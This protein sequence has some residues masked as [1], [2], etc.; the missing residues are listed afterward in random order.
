VGVE[1][2]HTRQVSDIDPQQRLAVLI[3]APNASL[4]QGG[5]ACL[6]VQWFRE[7]SKEGVDVRLLVHARSKPELDRALGPLSSRI[8][9]VSENALQTMIWKIGEAM[10]MNI[11]YF[12]AQLVVHL[13]TQIVQRGAAKRL[14][15]QYKINVVHEPMPVAPRFPSTMYGLGVPV[16]IG[17]MNGNMTY[18]PAY[19]SGRSRIERTFVPAARGFAN[20]ANFLIPGKRRADVLL[21]ANERTR[22]ALPSGCR[23]RVEILCE[24]GVDPHVWRRP[25]HLPARPADGLRIAFLGRLVDW[26]GVD[27]ALDVFAE[28]KKQIPSAQLSIIGD[29]PEL[30]SLQAQAARLGIADAVTFHGWVSA[31]D[32]PGLL[33]QSDVFLFPSVFDCGGAVVLEAMALGMAVVALNWGG[34]SDYISPD[35]GVLVEPA[36]RDQAVAELAGAV[37]ALTPGKRR[38]MGEAAQHRIANHYTWPAKARQI[39]KVYKSVCGL[40]ASGAASDEP[41]QR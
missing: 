7:L 15:K 33:A 32:C 22:L 14:I 30:A 18:P 8:H 28:V 4:I 5:E 40:T 19:R 39:L 37:L 13:I 21:V 12:T 26:K 31:D 17:P 2:F 3:V 38:D 20:L 35:D 6:P 10:P 24:N 29:G 11:R 1:T 9:Y 27:L 16:V 23:G 41:C 36:N 34:P 25:D